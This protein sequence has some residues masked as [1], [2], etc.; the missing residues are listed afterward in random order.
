MPIC[1][2]E[3]QARCWTNSSHLLECNP[4]ASVHDIV[5]YIV[6]SLGPTSAMKLEKL[7][8]YS[9]AWSLVWDS[10]PLFSARVEAWASGPVVPALYRHHRGQF[11][12]TSWPLGNPQNLRSFERESVDAVLKF[13]G[14]KTPFWLSELTHR[15][16]PW[17][18]AR[19]GLAP[20]ERGQT[21]ITHAAMAEYYGSL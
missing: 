9:Q 12:V 20:G 5:A 15:E 19:R 7:V 6:Q 2:S 21:E 18:D 8:Y 17:L 4:M 11:E 1:F 3:P 16:Q 14:D 13:Y 10:K